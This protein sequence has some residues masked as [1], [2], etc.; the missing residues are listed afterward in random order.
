MIDGASIPSNPQDDVFLAQALDLAGMGIGLSS[1]NPCV[2]AVIVDSSGKVV[3]TGTHTFERTQHAEVIALEQAGSKS[4]GGTLYINLEPCSH[5]GRTG[6]CTV[7]V[8]TAGIQRVLAAMPDPNPQV[9]GKGFDR[10]KSA[11]IVVDVVAGTLHQRARKLNESFAKFIR[12]RCPLVTLK[13]GMTLDGKIAPPPGESSNPSALGTG[14]A[15]GGYIT[16]EEARAHL[17]ELRHA[18]DAI[19]V[20]VG[21]VIADDPLLTDRSGLPRRRPL[22]RVILDSRLR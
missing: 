20:G 3:G 12:H 17:H 5:V 16:S 10:L 18:S 8:I 14:G 6:P 21:T 11:G 1:P 4:R 19:M 13:A 7:A 9:A 2:G 22:M 15:S